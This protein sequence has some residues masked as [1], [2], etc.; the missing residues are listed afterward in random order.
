[1]SA[2]RFFTTSFPRHA[3]DPAGHFVAALAA[4]L[5]E[6]GHAVSVEAAV[7][8]TSGGWAPPGVQVRAWD[9]GGLFGGEGAPDRLSSG[10]ASAWLAAASA[11]ARVTAR[12]VACR[13]KQHV[14]VGH[15]LL[16]C[17]PAALAAGGRVVLYAHG[18]D[19]ALL[20]RLPAGRAIARALDAGAD[21]LNFV[22]ADLR[23]RFEGLLGRP[24]RAA[25]TTLSMGLAPPAPDFAALDAILPA[26]R[27]GERRVVTVG[28]LV[29]LKGFDVLADALAG[30]PDVVWL[31]AGDGPERAALEHRCA[32]RG[33]RFVALGALAPGARDALLRR[34]DLFVLPSRP[35]DGRTEGTPLALLEAQLAGLPC[36]ASHLGG[37]PE[38]AAP[39]GT[40]LVPPNDPPAL[41]AALRALLDPPDAPNRRA[42]AG[43][44]CAAF[45]ERY[46]WARLMPAHRRAMLGN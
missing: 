1:V 15:W 29:R 37:V 22:S 40:T 9:R 41:T 6:D 25:V 45:A 26:P 11:L 18:G 17:G 4:G 43:A 28:R 33:V 46:T 31:A 19:I 42:R 5:A 21:H 30:L 24:P 44:A 32:A 13:R 16:P 3:D 2:V 27:P 20:E 14:S 34:A 38:A 10:G 36:I 8:A 12:G 7:A 23:R 35:L 39:G